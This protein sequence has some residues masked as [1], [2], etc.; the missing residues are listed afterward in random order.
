MQGSE[1]MLHRLRRE[2]LKYRRTSCGAGKRCR[3]GIEGAERPLLP[4]ECVFSESHAKDRPRLAIVPHPKHTLHDLFER[5]AR[6]SRPA[7]TDG[8]EGTAQQRPRFSAPHGR[9]GLPGDRN[10]KA[11][12]PPNKP[13]H[14]RDPAAQ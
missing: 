6:P 9:G 10:P 5:N 8:G 3:K 2:D 11:D 14:D 7:P 12:R 13:L 4:T 1:K